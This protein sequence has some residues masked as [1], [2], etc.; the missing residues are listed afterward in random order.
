MAE[1][2]KF[3]TSFLGGEVSDRFMAR[4]DS[5][6]YDKTLRISENFL[7]HPAGGLDFDPGT[8]FLCEAKTNTSPV[9]LI[10]FEKSSSEKYVLELTE[11]ACRFYKDKAR[12]LEGGNPLE[13]ITPWLAA[14]LFGLQIAQQEN[15]AYLAHADYQL[16][17]LAVFNDYAWNLSNA[18]IDV[19]LAVA[20]TTTPFATIYSYGS[21]TFSKRPNATTLPTGNAE[22]CAFSED[23]VYLAVGHAT[24]PFLSIYKRSG[25][26][27]EK[28]A[29]PTDLPP[30]LVRGCA[31]S[32]DSRYLAVCTDAT[33]FILI[34]KRTGDTFVKLSDP[35][36][37][38][39]GIPL[40]CF[41]SNSG[42]YLA[43]GN[44][45][46]PFLTIYKRNGDI[47]TKLPNPSPIPPGG[48]TGGCFSPNEN[49]LAIT[50]LTTPYIY[51]YKRDGDAFNKLSDPAS[52]PNGGH[53]CCFSSD[54][55]YLAV[56]HNATPYVLI[57]KRSGDS[58]IKL[59]DPTAG[60]AA[61]QSCAFSSG[62]N[63]LAVVSGTTP[64]VTIYKH[65]G[66]TF[67]KLSNPA[68][69][70]AGASKDCAF[71]VNGWE[72]VPWAS[73]FPQALTFHDQRLLVARDGTV[74]GSRTGW[75]Q[76]FTLDSLDAS[77]GF[78]YSLASDVLEEIIWMRTK[79]HNVVVGTTLGEW[80]LTGGDAPITGSNVFADRVSGNGS[81][82]I[83]AVLANASLLYVQKGGQRLL[84]FLYSQERGGY[85]SPDLTLL[86]DHIGELGFQELAWQRSP[87]S[88]LW[89]RLGTGEL[90]SLT[91]D[92]NNSIVA[93]G[94]HPRDG[95]IKSLAIV[96]GDASNGEDTIY[97]CV[98]R[99]INGVTKQ[100]IEYMQPQRRPSDE[101]DYHF[102]DCGKIYDYSATQ[103]LVNGA[104]SYPLMDH[105]DC[106]SVDIPHVQD[107]AESH[108]S[109]TCARSA[110]RAYQ[111]SYSMKLTK[112]SASGS[113]G[114][115]YFV[116]N[117]LTTDLHGFV[118]GRKYKVTVRFYVPPAGGPSPSEIVL[119][120]GYYD[121]GAWT[122]ISQAASLSDSWESIQ[123]EMTIP[124]SAT[125]ATAL[126]LLQSTAEA[127]EY[128]YFDDLKARSPVMVTANGHPFV[129]DEFVRITGI[130]GMTQL[131]GNSYM[132]KSKTTNT[133]ELYLT[134]GVTFADGAEM[135]AYV[136][137]GLLEKVVKALS[138]LDHLEAK[139]VAVYADGVELGQEVVSAGAITID[140][141][142]AKI[143]VGLPYTGKMWTQRLGHFSPVRIPEA[144]LLLSKSRGGKIGS[145]EASLKAI[146][147][148]T[149]DLKTG[150]QRV[151]IGG[152]FSEEGSIMIV[153]DQPL[154]MSILGI[155][156]KLNVGE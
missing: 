14:D 44:G 155:V 19:S 130:V 77:F 106:E 121:S 66:D 150:A 91:L 100:Y 30:A 18:G 56:A 45:T 95:I 99:V 136:S 122:Y 50:S 79:A 129:N 22:A 6:L 105:G 38:P 132:V 137:G 82:E 142:A 143:H 35:A 78:E 115:Q 119:R 141:Y 52:L 72:P 57:Y 71:V 29:N 74:W 151:T 116:D 126:L 67:T 117:A 93:W 2:R 73:R 81:A 39:P 90:A 12:L 92:R 127:G 124:A 110:D 11:L 53:Q 8:V 28:I 37:L 153:Q 104:A 4:V 20:H 16:H 111:G 96:S 149:V 24:T 15:K 51:I 10:P 89:T 42:T 9:R 31:F 62:D 60:P 148:D 68:D 152:K 3:N 23:G 103:D 7:L 40:R 86:A 135:G 47:F 98:Q 5:P 55:L 94:R 145:D 27:Y 156:G 154:P 97:L 64:Y 146:R 109:C 144:L 65:A 139:T 147:Y 101:K 69:L 1:G 17:R 21:D 70:P 85:V 123:A 108:Y 118:A 33:P 113:T 76:D 61:G 63:Y 107:D 59:A 125:A 13:I 140:Q 134:D 34:Y 138:G 36:D 26:K 46:T 128:I 54:N 49:Y 75:P 43:A 58:F 112:T 41:F 84:E 114:G 83:C 131:N 48:G 120:I 32:L 88:M 133:F 102:V 87:S 25:E 80:L